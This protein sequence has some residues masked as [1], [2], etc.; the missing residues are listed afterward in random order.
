MTL[1]Q[2]FSRFTIL[3][4][5]IFGIS[6]AL[7]VAA[8]TDQMAALELPAEQDA[9]AESVFDDIFDETVFA[10]S[11]T[12]DSNFTVLG[13]AFVSGE[14]LGQ[15]TLTLSENFRTNRGPELVV[16]LRSAS[17][18]VWSLG[19]LQQTS[20]AQVLEIPGLI[21]LSVFNEVEIFDEQLS[22][23]FGSAQL[24]AVPA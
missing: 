15:R 8:S 14:N 11:F 5:A 16:N 9:A 18:E 1:R 22:V 17:G 13:E 2:F 23:A 21:D 3:G 12:G 6:A 4:I 24:I 10:G 7:I 19:T 20:G